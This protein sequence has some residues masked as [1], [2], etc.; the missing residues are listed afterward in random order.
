MGN[1]GVDFFQIFLSV[2]DPNKVSIIIVV[3]FPFGGTTG[4]ED[5]IIAVASCIV[6]N[7]FSYAKA[8]IVVL[9]MTHGITRNLTFWDTD[10][11]GHPFAFFREKSGHGIA[12]LE[13]TG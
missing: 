3:Q 5:A 11:S 7:R 6:K 12:S 1:L 9:I 8:R 10:S 4:D 13:K 2:Y